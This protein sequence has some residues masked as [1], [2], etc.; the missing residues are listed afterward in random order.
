MR[1][2]QCC[3]W[4]GKSSVHDRKKVDLGWVK[5]Q[6]GTRYVNECLGYNSK[7]DSQE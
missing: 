6:V 5:V 3:K 7:V 4:G 2:G 1:G